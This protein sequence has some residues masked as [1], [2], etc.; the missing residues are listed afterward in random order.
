MFRGF[1]QSFHPDVGTV[2]RLRHDRF[3]PNPFKHISHPT[4]RRCT[5]DT[6]CIAKSPP[7]P[8][9]WELCP[10]VLNMET[11]FFWDCGTFYE[12]TRCHITENN[13]LH[14]NYRMMDVSFMLYL[15]VLQLNIHTSRRRTKSRAEY[16]YIHWIQ[17]T[18]SKQHTK[19]EK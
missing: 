13:N 3:L 18:P 8:N 10:C 19:H 6:E 9:I 4:V 16:E 11:V 12:T 1:L 2:P 5:A 17:N 14:D 15:T 7:S